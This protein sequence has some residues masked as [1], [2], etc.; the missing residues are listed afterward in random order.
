MSAKEQ[1]QG[2]WLDLVEEAMKSDVSKEEFKKFIEGKVKEL[3][4]KDS[5]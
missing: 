4:T 3:K 1:L 5:R 2:E